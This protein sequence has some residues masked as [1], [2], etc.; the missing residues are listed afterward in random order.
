MEPKAS[1]ARPT[2]YIVTNVVYI[3]TNVVVYIV[4]FRGATAAHSAGVEHGTTFEVDGTPAVAL[5]AGG[6]RPDA[7]QLG[8]LVHLT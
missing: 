1:R 7:E 5:N 6:Q 4:M 3:V 2:V 8:D